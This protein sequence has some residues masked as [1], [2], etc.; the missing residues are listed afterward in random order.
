[1]SLFMIKSI[2]AIFFILA[3]FIATFSMLTLMGK[4]ERKTS[5]TFLRRMHK[6]SGL[7]FI[8][9]LLVL[10]YLCL[11]YWAKAGDQISTRA[12]F[13]GVLSFAVIGVLILK[14]SIVRFYKQFLRFAPVMGLTVFTLSFVVFSI[15]AGFFFL[16]T[17]CA[18]DSMP[19]VPT[20]QAIIR[21]NAENGALLF[22]N[23][24][25]FCHYP[26]RE[27]SK[28]GPGLKN[29]LKKERLPASGRP[30]NIENIKAQ[31][32]APFLAM[33]SFSALADQ[34]IADLIAYL[35]KL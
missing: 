22:A 33:P 13:H 2:L 18:K 21:G 35:E 5:A 15:S 28:Q 30:A 29:I 20:S 26:D 9:F 24:C 14:L 11:R 4:T 32:K 27:E 31:L 25:S 8:A 6:S 1:M 12:V 10:A 16:R 34:E 7:V 23:M 17:F 3:A 19:R